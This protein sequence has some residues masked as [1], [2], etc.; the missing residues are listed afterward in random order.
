[1]QLGLS[2][3]G[4]GFL[5]RVPCL[6]KFL[7]EYDKS[8]VRQ[9]PFS[10][11]FIQGQVELLGEFRCSR[12][13]KNSETPLT[14]NLGSVRLGPVASGKTRLLQRL[15]VEASASAGASQL[16]GSC[17]GF[18]CRTLQDL[19]FRAPGFGGFK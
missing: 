5:A 8:V 15:A 4:S 9:V 13:R 12:S 3:A 18:L 11:I 16:A 19:E 10:G 6:L 14:F 1:M 7:K 17:E 2:C